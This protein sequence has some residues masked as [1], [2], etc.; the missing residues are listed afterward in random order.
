[1]TRLVSMAVAGLLLFGPTWKST[2]QDVYT[3]H[4][5]GS[6]LGTIDTATGLGSDVG[7]FGLPGFPTIAN[8]AAFDYDD[9]ATLYTIVST[10]GNEATANSY[11]GTIDPA[12]GTITQVASPWNKNLLALE[13]DQTGRLLGVGFTS[14]EIPGV[15]PSLQLY[16]DTT[17]YEI[18]KSTGHLTSLVDLNIPR[19][20]D[21]AVDSV[22]TVFGTTGNVLY[23]IDSNVG[24]TSQVDITGVG[25]GEIM[26]IMFG[27][28]DTLYATAFTPDSPLFTIDVASGVA[29][30]FGGTATP[31]GLVLPHGGDIATAQTAAGVLKG[32]MDAVAHMDLNHGIAT[33]LSQKLG[34]TFGLVTSEVEQPDAIHRMESFMHYVDKQGGRQIDTDDAHYLLDNSATVISL[35]DAGALGAPTI[36]EPSG[37]TLILWALLCLATGLHRR[38]IR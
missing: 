24:A 26:G 14:G 22:G 28:D 30:P 8:S 5:P 16:G 29:T 20:M 3:A 7:S 23:T 32:M 15:P 4:G 27:D 19:V 6:N 31:T 37:I 11:L 2:A 9:Q 33:S 10:L 1:M 17:L 38:R 34:M 18:D 13:I 25:G 12:S 35:L 36:P 21:L